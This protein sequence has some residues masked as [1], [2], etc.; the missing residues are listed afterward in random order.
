MKPAT[1]W[2]LGVVAALALT[3]GANLWV[4]H[5][6]GDR[7]AAVVEPDYYR[8]ALAWDSTLAQ[9]ARD[10]A[11]G[12]RVAADLG[13]LARDGRAR[14]AVRL[15]DRDGHAVRAAAV[16]LEAVHNLDAARPRRAT[17]APDGDGYAA[18]VPLGR[19]GLWEL[20]LDVRRGADHFVTCLRRDAVVTR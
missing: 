9:Q 20:R 12:W 13:P 8:K 3:V 2:P 14:V 11:L 7:D 1:L 15:L 4:L 16:A 5:L 10:R 17:L 6:A 19:P 18:E